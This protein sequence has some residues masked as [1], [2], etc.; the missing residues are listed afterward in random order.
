LLLWIAGREI[1][2]GNAITASKIFAV[3]SIRYESSIDEK[4]NS[5][6]S[7]SIPNR[8]VVVSSMLIA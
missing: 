1:A 6:K 8:F 5:I 4:A 2:E 3:L 7:D